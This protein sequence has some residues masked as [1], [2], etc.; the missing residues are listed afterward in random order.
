MTRY[1]W[2]IELRAHAVANIYHVC[3]VNKVGLDTGG[4]TRD[5]HGAS[6]IV[7]PRGEI[8]AQASDTEAGLVMADV[9]L[10]LAAELRALWGY[11]ENRRPDLYAPLV[12]Q[13]AEPARA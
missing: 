2:D 5:H 3:G 9:D 6:M 12:E 7:N 1:L 10:S 11:Y 8:L 4:S 13:D